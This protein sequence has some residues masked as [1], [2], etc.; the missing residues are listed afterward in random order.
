MHTSIYNHL[1]LPCY[2][3]SAAEDDFLIRN[4]S[5][6]EYKLLES[7]HGFFNSLDQNKRLPIFS[8][9]NNCIQR[10]SIL[11]NLSNISVSHLQSTLRQLQPGDFL[12]LYF[13]TQ[14]AAILIEID[15]VPSKQPLISS[16]QVLLPT[17]DITSSLTPHFSCFPT[18]KFRLSNRT[19]LSKNV[20]CE[21]LIEFLTN[22]IEYS[23]TQK[24]S[25]T[26]NETRDVPESHYVCQWWIQ[27]LQGIKIEND[28][29][30]LVQF[31]KKHRDQIRWKHSATPFRRSG[32]WM[33][34]KVI[35]QT[36]LT[37]RLG[38]LGNLIYKLLITL[39]LTYYINSMRTANIEIDNLVHG[40]RKIARRLNKIDTNL[41]SFVNCSEINGWIKQV[42]EEIQLTIRQMISKWNWQDSFRI[43]S[44]RI[45]FKNVDHDQLYHHSCRKLN[46][47]LTK[48]TS[49]ASSKISNPFD[50]TFIDVHPVD[51]IPSMTDLT[52]GSNYTIEMALT[53]QELWIE[54]SLEQWINRSFKSNKNP[55]ELLLN[56]YEEYQNTA[57]PHYSEHHPMGYSRFLLTSLTLLSIM[58]KKLIQ[59]KRFSRLK[60]HSIAIPNLVE[61][62]DL[63]ILPNRKEMIR[64]HD[65][66][67]YF[68]EF[69]NKSF[70][71]LLSKISSSE[72]FGVLIAGQS[73]MM[74]KCLDEIKAEAERDRKAKI[75][76]VNE[77]KRKYTELIATVNNL[78]CECVSSPVLSTCRRCST[79]DQANN[80]RVQ[81]Y[82]CPIP[83]D[84]DL[85]LAVV[86]EL[87][88]PHE[89]R[90]YREIL[91]QFVNR[92]HPQPNN[93]QMFE[94]SKVPPHSTRLA[95]FN[96]CPTTC[97]VKLVSSEKSI[98]QS[99]Y[100]TPLCVASTLVESFLYENSLKVQISPT[101]PIPSEAEYKRFSPRIDHPDYKYL[102]FTIGSTQFEQNKVI[103]NLSHC[104]EQLMPTQF[105]EFGSF[106][107]GHCL[108]WWNL[109]IIFEMDSLP[110]HE[111]SV[112]ILIMHAILQSGP[113]ELDTK[114]LDHPWCPKSHQQIL[115]DHFVD[116]LISRLNRRL[117]DCELN[118]HSELVLVVI[119][120]I[121]MRIFTICNET[122]IDRVSE[123]IFTC[124]RI[125]EKWIDLI[126]DSIQSLSTS[127]LKEI[128]KLRAKI[129][130]IVNSCLF[131]FSTH[132]ERMHYILWSEAHMIS[133]LRAATTRHDNIT[134][135]KN[136]IDLSYLMKTL[137]HWSEHILVT[138]QPSIAALLERESYRSLNLF[139]VIYWATIR[140]RS[141]IDGKWKKRKKDLYDG[142][143]DGQFKS[144]NISIDCL[145]GTFLVNGM[146]VGFLP[147]Q[148]TSDALF[149]RVFDHHIFEVQPDVSNNTYITK[150][151]YHDRKV[152][153]EFHYND[154]MNRLIIAE[155][156]LQNE[157]VFEL[158]PSDI[159]EDEFPDTLYRI[160]AI[161]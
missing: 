53:Y 67:K 116:E 97:K 149:L 57:L 76:E 43:E 18:S 123:L 37:Q 21:L 87:Q 58:H 68:K 46:T 49:D 135:N 104:S 118:W 83:S 141:Q 114:S 91:W 127:D 124:R 5:H 103:A 94:W 112:V 40:I 11:Q 1:F 152:H 128:N 117:N 126:S 33:T 28:T 41:S 10:W 115:E 145:K 113:N 107:S 110:I 102:E 89:L 108:Q 75:Q 77:A 111:E 159:F 69:A 13:H 54:L 140:N 98:T 63:L 70:P 38:T 155:R 156:Y 137:L 121:T 71:H 157:N 106:R 136:Q 138:I 56:F 134:L 78:P 144:T 51:S 82:E 79:L 73:T 150:H 39:F 3:P 122:R 62:F 100:N 148:I 146:T 81:I 153:Y 6:N 52:N 101:K 34:I 120:I 30:K 14:N 8:V 29:N 142:W 59:D 66:Y 24:S 96:T 64:A 72:A 133:F 32:L 151:P 95:R 147:E 7:I 125:G 22:T 16:W 109:L 50:F 20:H 17:K 90:C 48:K 74:L 19:E 9:L 130:T 4:N 92:C 160:T 86:F 61:M 131:T 80:I 36:I 139:S 60:F 31:K 45:S 105:V 93:N 129:V 12:P 158:L 55:F 23:K 84:R 42:K 25:Y 47:Y 85:A 44:P 65:L 15:E 27:Q 88:M 35:L 119:I 99:H 132:P 26:F 2:L 143:Y 161:G 154:R